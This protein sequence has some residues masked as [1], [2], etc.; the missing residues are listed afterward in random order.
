[1]LEKQKGNLRVDKL[2]AILLYEAD[3]NQNNKKLGKDM[4]Y[5]AEDLKAIAKEQFGSRSRMTAIDQSLNKRLTYDI[6]RQTRRPGALC[7][8]DAKS[9]YDRIVHSVASL[10]MQRVGAPVEPIV[11]MFTTIQNLQHRIRTVYGDSDL[12]FSGA[13][14]VV[15]IQGVGQGNGA[16]PQIWAVVS[17]PVF[18]ML[19][20]MGFG[21]HL[22]ATISGE[23][24]EFVGFAFVDDTDLVETARHTLETVQEVASRMQES[25]TA[26]EGGLRATGGAIVPEKSHWYLIDFVWKDGTWRYAT[27]AETN[28]GLTVKDCYGHS[29][30]IERLDVSDARR[31]LGVRLAPDGNNDAEVQFLTER[32]KDW[33][34]RVR[35]GHLPRRLVWESMN[36]TIFKSLQYPLPAT[37]LSREQCRAI[38]APL[39]AQGLSASGIVRTMPRVVVHGP[40]KF[41]GLGVS[42]LFTFQKIQH[43]L[44]ILKFCTAADNITGQLIRHSLEATKLEI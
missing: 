22:K 25:L 44:R 42:D 13:M 9:C 11:C 1:M 19:R 4:M 36:T 31:T 24:L 3:F 6:I 38:M 5:T 21:A 20:S 30:T 26:W 17:T 12:T 2:R 27:L 41:Q 23:R 37:T 28:L 15:P 16:G 32:A 35:T 8:N 10:A 39:L 33:A 40:I 14:Y 7:S 29:K 18:N 34:D 43:I